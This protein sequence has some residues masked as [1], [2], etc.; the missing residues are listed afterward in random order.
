GNPRAGFEYGLMMDVNFTENYILATGITVTMAGGNLTYTDSFLMKILADSLF[1]GDVA[2]KFKLQYLNLPLV[3]KM[4]TK[5]IGQFRYYGGLGLISAFRFKA[6]ADAEANGTQIF[7]NDNIVKNK[8]QTGGVFKS[9]VYNLSLNVEGGM[10]F[11][12]SDKTALV[13]AIF[14]R[15][16]F[17]NVLIDRDEDKISLNN[18]G[19]RIGV[20]F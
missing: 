11:P 17:V 1:A 20:L 9:V 16:G 7:D 2:A 18:L 10:E 14:Y 13:A 12:F 4:R 8:D 5:E 15:N 6:R 3:F 19:L